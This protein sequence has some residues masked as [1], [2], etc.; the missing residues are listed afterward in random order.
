MVLEDVGEVGE[1]HEL[2]LGDA[3]GASG[4][5]KGVVVGGEEGE[6]TRASEDLVEASL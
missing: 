5:C 1:V 2:N 6:G 3:Q 4:I